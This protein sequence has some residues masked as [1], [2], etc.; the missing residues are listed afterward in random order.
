M[1]MDKSK[2]L[3]FS[4]SIHPSVI[5]PVW[6][7][8]SGLIAGTTVDAKMRKFICVMDVGRWDRCVSDIWIKE[9]TSSS[10]TINKSREEYWGHN[11]LQWKA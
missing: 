2:V 11:C 6:T 3:L 7:T 10:S 5:S 8:I 1:R 4:P 9:K